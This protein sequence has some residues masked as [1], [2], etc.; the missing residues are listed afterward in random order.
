MRRGGV[1]FRSPGGVGVNP[2]WRWARPTYE[3]SINIPDIIYPPNI[4]CLVQRAERNER[5]D[6]GE[7]K[8]RWAGFVGRCSRQP[9]GRN[10]LE[11]ASRSSGNVDAVKDGDGAS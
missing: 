10:K 5:K 9:A 8:R 4:A 3:P 1:V 2:G 11:K 7:E 6:N